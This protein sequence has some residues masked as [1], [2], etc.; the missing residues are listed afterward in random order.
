[1]FIHVK[2]LNGFQQTLTYSVPKEWDT[3]NLLGSLVQVPLRNRFETAYVTHLFSEIDSTIN[4]AI[5]AAHLR[6]YLPDDPHYNKFNQ[7]MS[8]Y[9]ALDPLYMLKRIRNFLHEK[10]YIADVQAA[11]EINTTAITLTLEQQHIVTTLKPVIENPTYFP[12]LIH[13]V[14]GSGKTEIYKQ[15]ILQTH[16]TGKTTLLLLPEVSLAVQFTTLLRKQL[17]EHIIIVGFHSAT[18]VKEKRTLWHYLQHKKPLVIIGVHLPL[19]LPVPLLGLIIVDEEHE[20]GYQEKKFPRINTKEAAILRAQLHNIPIILGSATP[21]LSSLYNV[22]TR[23][24]HFFSLKKRFAGAFPNITLVKLTGKTKRAHFWLSTELEKSITE[25]LEKKEQTIIFL[26][27]RGFSF[28]IQCKK[29]GLIPSCTNCSVSLTLH[30]NHILKCHYCG[31]AQ[32]EYTACPGCKA[33]NEQFIKKGIGTQQVVSILEKLFPQARIGR[34]DMDTTVNKKNWSKTITD[35]EA[36]NLDILVGTQTITKGYHFP[37]VTLVGI[38]W[39]D[40]NLG[41]PVYNAAEVTLQQLIQVAGRAGRQSAES[42]VIVQHMLDHPL[43]NYLQEITYPDF[44]EAEMV[45][46]AAVQYPPFIRL[47]D[48]ELRHDNPTIVDKEAEKLADYFI[49]YS[50]TH[51]LDVTVLGPA[52]PAVHKIK[53]VH[54]RKIYLKSKYIKSL[55]HLYNSIDRSSFFS[56]ILFTPNPVS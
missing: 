55:L 16:N 45:N 26:N 9:Y 40:I 11:A 14:T 23:G 12:S 44:Y 20:I 5:K 2:L 32:P 51:K 19:L 24:W 36:G 1:M 25:Q 56:F 49:Q 43:F 41:L 4:Y 54:I 34:A 30:N 3:Q 28:F 10:E 21:C 7:Q 8:T 35:F 22:K 47:A 13:G 33:S 46:R 50:V 27:R 53:N 38:L 48:I 29:C 42:K 6:E 17:P 15:L 37:K 31:L 39:A 18:S 52:Q